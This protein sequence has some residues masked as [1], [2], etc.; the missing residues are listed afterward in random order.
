M[1]QACKIWKKCDIAHTFKGLIYEKC[2]LSIPFPPDL[3][4]LTVLNDPSSIYYFY[5]PKKQARVGATRGLSLAHQASSIDLL[6]Q[7][8]TLDPALKASEA[9]R[10]DAIRL[11][12]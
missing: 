10:K 2:T 4:L 6:H 7:P 5:S 8:H 12:L 1:P 11:L 9:R 3:L